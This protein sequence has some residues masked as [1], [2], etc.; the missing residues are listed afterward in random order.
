VENS[1]PA[2]DAGAVSAYQGAE[3]AH[4]KK[5]KFMPELAIGVVAALLFP[6]LAIIVHQKRE[7]GRNR[8]NGRRRNDKIKLN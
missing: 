2:G 8:R 6:I 5:R 3:D 4:R 7:S 1:A